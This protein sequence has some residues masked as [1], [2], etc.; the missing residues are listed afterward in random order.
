MNQYYNRTKQDSRN[1]KNKRE[2]RGKG[3]KNAYLRLYPFFPGNPR[4]SKWIENK[5]RGKNVYLL[6]C[7]LL[8]SRDGIVSK[9]SV[10]EN[11]QRFPPLQRF[12]LLQRFYFSSIYTT[13]KQ[14]RIQEI[15][16]INEKLGEKGKKMPT[17]DYTPFFSLE[18]L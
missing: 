14:N 10:A 3:G 5:K 13:I 7:L 12:S 8:K 11:E 17:F 18:T 1:C 9:L 6:N 4:N 15:A 2:I 16:K